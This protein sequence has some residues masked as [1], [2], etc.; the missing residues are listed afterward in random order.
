MSLS[1]EASNSTSPP[2]GKSTLLAAAPRIIDADSD[3][4]IAAVT[5]DELKDVYRLVETDMKEVGELMRNHLRHPDQAVDEILRYSVR[6][7]GKRLRPLL[8]LLCARA[9]GTVR[10]EHR[11][12]AA[13]I[14]MIHTGT[15]IH[16]DIL[17]GA[18]FRR[19]L[20]TINL[21]WDSQYAVLVGDLLL[22]KAI[23]L[24]T[25][26]A[27]QKTD[28]V[29]ADSCRRTCEGELMQVAFR[30]R[31]DMTTAD[32]MRIIEGKT[33]SLIETSCRLGAAFAEVSP[34]TAALFAR[35]GRLLGL[36]F[37]IFDDVLDLVGNL[38]ETGKTLG[39]DLLNHKPTLPLIH[40]LEKA[41]ADEKETILHRLNSSNFDEKDAADIREI[42]EASGA[43]SFARQA[44]ADLID[45]G[46]AL[47]DS[48]PPPENPSQ[49]EARLAL[50]KVARFIVARNL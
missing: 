47:L 18:E 12:L 35:F 32:Y 8:L 21:R 46:I 5:P 45:E 16:D 40:Y 41:A 15:L 3:S 50:Q 28:D 23:S 25:E 38:D 34:K 4:T 27:D 39:T 30:N 10:R 24:V 37:Q 22:T 44:A 6:L 36:A 13:A 33:A 1:Q 20:E 11:L 49:T 9:C 17:D 14:E 19:H 43:I 48:F 2:A 26:C 29:I 42:L 31:F 7:G